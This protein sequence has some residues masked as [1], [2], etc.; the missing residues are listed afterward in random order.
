MIHKHTISNSVSDLVSWSRTVCRHEGKSR[1]WQTSQRFLNG[2]TAQKVLALAHSKKV[3]LSF[4]ISSS[5]LGHH[6]LTLAPQLCKF[7]HIGSD[8]EHRFLTKCL[9]L[10][11]I[12]I[13]QIEFFQKLQLFDTLPRF[14]TQAQNSIDICC[15]SNIL[16]KIPIQ[17]IFLWMSANRNPTYRKNVAQEKILFKFPTI[18]LSL[19][20]KEKTQ[21]LL[22]IMARFCL[23]NFYLVGNYKSIHFRVYG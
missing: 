13:F 20:W 1:P 18:P 2:E 14:Q 7:K 21:A 15:T 8:C 3:W 11:G 10:G 16:L 23:S 9:T 19:I 12:L 5:Y 17:A 4:L 22:L 6:A